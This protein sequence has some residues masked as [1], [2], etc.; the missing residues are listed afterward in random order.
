MWEFVNYYDMSELV[1]D[2]GGA[3]SNDGQVGEITITNCSKRYTP[4]S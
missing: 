2:C 4:I 1:S 3:I